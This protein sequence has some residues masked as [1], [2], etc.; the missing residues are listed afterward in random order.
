M[1]DATDITDVTVIDLRGLKCPAP[2]VRLNERIGELDTGT[3]LTALA[4]D[5]AFELD[6][7]AW[8]R[9]TGHELLSLKTDSDTLS[10]S[11]RKAGA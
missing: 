2:I 5:R 6:V 1:S 7:Q 11:I 3:Q 4:D 8:C 10:A 9:R